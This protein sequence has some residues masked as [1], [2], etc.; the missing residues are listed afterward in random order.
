MARFAA[1]SLP[2]FAVGELRVVKL[3]PPC[4]RS[5]A[6]VERDAL[7]A[8]EGRLPIPTP[9]VDACGELDGWTYVV[10]ERLHGRGLAEAWSE[11]DRAARERLAEDVG[12]ATAALHG[13]DPATVGAAVPRPDW[14]AFIDA[15]RV[16]CVERQRA[17][18]L[19][20]EWLERLP[21]FLDDV[22][23]EVIVEVIVA[24]PPRRAL[25]H[26]EIMREH[27]LVAKDAGTWRL[28]GLF[29]FEPA[30]IGDPDYE[31]ASIGVFVT[32][33]DAKLLSRFVAGY[34]RD[35]GPDVF[36]TYALLHRYSNL[37]WYLERVP[38][39]GAETIEELA[40][41]WWPG[42]GGE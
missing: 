15:Q 19:A 13:I 31:L 29:D 34:G 22:I 4:F 38:A 2:V 20:P 39:R 23:D 9:R 16:A 36:M 5:E 1:G 33:G 6:E 12:V 35:P 28:S 26:T 27:L 11:I 42:E 21:A 25:L 24:A 3:F 7:M 8:V 10:M 30:M 14:L 37:R 17:R 32:G 40:R 41:E 18:G